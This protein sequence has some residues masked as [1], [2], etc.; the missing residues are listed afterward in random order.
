VSAAT[1]HHGL[2]RAASPLDATPGKP[3]GVLDVELGA[4]LPDVPPAPAGSTVTVLARLHGAPVGR[5]TLPGGPD[6]LPADRL[7]ALLWRDADALREHLAAD[8]LPVPDALGPAGLPGPPAPPC[9]RGRTA[10]PPFVSVVVATRDRTDSL[11]RCLRSLAAQDH[12]G[13]AEVVI[14]DNA[15]STD[16]TQRAVA[17]LDGR[18]GDLDV[19]YVRE[20]VPGLARA[21]NRGLEVARG[22]WLAITDDDVVADPGWLSAIAAA[23]RR[24]P[25][26]GAVTGLILA[27]ELETRAQ[28]LLEQYGGFARGFTPR[29][30]DLGTHRPADPLF[31]LTTGRIGSGANMAFERGLLASLG[32][33]DAAMGAGTPARGGDDLAGL[34]AVLQAGRT[35]AYAPSAVVWHWHR[36]EYEG[37]LR[38]AR[39]YGIGLGAYLTGALV[40]DPRL[41]TTML[42][43]AR[44]ALRHLLD[45][46]SEKN[47]M[48]APD[49]PRELERAERVGVLLGPWCYARSRWTHRGAR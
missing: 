21:H 36:R 22:D 2:R 44:P 28:D 19:R 32:G 20:P 18:L 34:L 12:T 25:G 40:H 4:A 46:S 47:R 17:S 37:L 7:A 8:G 1:G 9:R 33:F 23:A 43:G 31:P 13:R 35:I 24:A 10:A 16:A 27:A 49:F 11:L 48:K 5:V 39:H 38:Q 45:R 29:L 15:P 26:I 42:R 3:A 14:V 41:V 30:F 6:G